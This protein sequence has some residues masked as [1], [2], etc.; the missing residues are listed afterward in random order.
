MSEKKESATKAEETKQTSVK[1]HYDKKM[2]QRARDRKRE[3]REQRAWKITGIV[4][5]AAICAFIL[6]FPIRKYL[7]IHETIC[8]IGGHD[9]SRVEFDYN[10][11]MIKNSYMNSYG[12]YLSYYGMDSEHIEDEMYDGSLTFRD[13]FEKEAVERIKQ[14]IALK[15]ELE[16]EG[17]T[18]DISSDYQSY[19]DTMKENADAAGISVG[20]LYTQS[21]GIYATPRRLEPFVRESLLVSKFTD[22][23][24]LAFA[25]DDAAIDAR[26]AE[27]ADEYD[28]F[29]YRLTRIDAELP[30]AP[31]E[32]ADEGAAVAEDGSYTPSEAEVEAAMKEAKKLADDAEAKVL[33]D[34]DLHEGETSASVV[35]QIRNWLLDSSRKNG[36]TTVVESD[37][38]NCY[39]VVGFIGRYVDQED[40]ISLRIISTSEDNGA[41]IVSEY[42]AAGSTEEAFID[43]VSRYSD[44]DNGNG[45]LYEGLSGAEL[46]GDIS[47][48]MTDSARKMG[49]VT[50][51]YDE[52]ISLTYVC[53]YVGG[54]KPSWYYN[55]KN[56]IASETMEDYLS[57]LTADMT[58]ADPKGNLEYIALEA[59]SL[60]LQESVENVAVTPAE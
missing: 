36:D 9:V 21:L 53:Y 52:S 41:A 35:Y 37:T 50:Y 48:W 20:E 24:Q 34:G 40:T 13:Y 39:Y 7:A 3:K 11:N 43:L 25:P 10:Y 33:Q 19:V 42:N 8:T 30:T 45:G 51:Y 14:T 4:I 16:R 23:K 29:D 59:A 22:S 2:E 26:Y 31:T 60:Q 38:I 12:Q 18:A 6:S 32:L 1:T 15:E 49:D 44:S 47:T 28:L 54:G 57:G 27:D 56:L 46:P 17:F 55:I 5:I 58:V